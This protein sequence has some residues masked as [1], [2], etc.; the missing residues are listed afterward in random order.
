MLSASANVGL[1]FPN[2][3]MRSK[4]IDEEIRG[5]D[6]MIE[7]L[8]IANLPREVPVGSRFTKSLI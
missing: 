1:P 6:T 2:W 7:W 5:E 4:P 8:D 3:R